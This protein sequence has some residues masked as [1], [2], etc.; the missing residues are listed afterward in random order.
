MVNDFD[1]MAHDITDLT[2]KMDESDKINKVKET[3]KTIPSPFD[4]NGEPNG[5]YS[6]TAMSGVA[7]PKDAKYLLKTGGKLHKVFMLPNSK[8]MN[9]TGKMALDYD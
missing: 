9:A 7:A 4:E 3:E 8:N 6:S 1:R 2:D 5:V